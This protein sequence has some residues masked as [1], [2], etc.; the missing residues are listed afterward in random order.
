MINAMLADSMH[1]GTMGDMPSLVLTTK[2]KIAD[3]RLVSVTMFSPRPALRAP[4]GAKNAPDFK[5]YKEAMKWLNGQ[6]FRLS[7]RHL[8]KRIA[9]AIIAKGGFKPSEIVIMPIEVI[10]SNFQ[11]GKLDAAMMWEPHA[12][13]MVDLGNAKYAPTSPAW[14]SAMLTSR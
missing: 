12:R 10:T 8:R 7:P 1:I 6:A 3:L 11:A 2:G 9:E 5:D 14:K 13:R 4:G